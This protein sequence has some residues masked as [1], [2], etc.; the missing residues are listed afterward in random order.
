[1]D[2]TKKYQMTS[3]KFQTISNDQNSKL[4]TEL[5]WSFGIGVWNL[6]VIWD[7]EIGI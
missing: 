1:M 7:L 2:R 6:F 5:F 3:A 4:K